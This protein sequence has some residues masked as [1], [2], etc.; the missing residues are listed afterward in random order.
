MNAPPA[1]QPFVP[2]F[3]SAR[4]PAPGL[5]SS[6]WA[7]QPQPS[8]T[9]W[10]KAIE[11][12]SRVH[13]DHLKEPSRPEFRRAMSNPANRDSEDVFGAVGLAGVGTQDKRTIGAVGDG[14][15]RS[16]PDYDPMVSALFECSFR[17]SSLSILQHVHQ[18]LRTLNLNSPAPLA[19]ESFAT[20]F[21]PSPIS[22]DVSP[23]STTSALLTPPDQSPAKGFGEWKFNPSYDFG[24]AYQSHGPN[25]LLFEVDPHTIPDYT[26]SQQP[27]Y[28]SMP[29]ADPLQPSIRSF[30][31]FEPFQERLSA[32]PSSNVIS[33]REPIL[34]AHLRQESGFAHSGA[35]APPRIRTSSLEWGR[36]DER[37]DSESSAGFT[38]LSFSPSRSRSGSVHEVSVCVR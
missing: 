11:S 10:S 38:E 36:L 25:S 24:A 12:I 16:T 5:S 17:Q 9:T 15:K 23:I 8:D 34:P 6:I 21:L 2:L 18:L 4:R 33:V 19:T 22:P 29:P 26:T 14:R 27:L 7:P 3:E 13:E 1:S 32:L 31:G 28:R 35:W 20:D 37:R 30:H